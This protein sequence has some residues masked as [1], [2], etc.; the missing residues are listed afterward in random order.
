MRRRLTLVLK[1]LHL[2]LPGKHIQS[3]VVLQRMEVVWTRE[4]AAVLEPLL[5]QGHG[6]L[7]RVRKCV[8]VGRSESAI[9]SFVLG[10]QL[11]EVWTVRFQLSSVEVGLLAILPS[12]QAH[13]V[14]ARVRL[15]EVL[16]LGSILP[17]VFSGNENGWSSLGRRQLARCSL[18]GRSSLCRSL[19]WCCSRLR[20]ERLSRWR[21]GGGRLRWNGRS[22]GRS[23]YSWLRCTWRWLGWSRLSICC[24]CCS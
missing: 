3:K 10:E 24:L 22:R 11:P 20:W 7:V 18:H 6:K 15:V 12:V 14:L 8:L 13:G 2:E 1:W 9:M 19:L 5:H 16:I 21:L 23:V 4:L 17:R